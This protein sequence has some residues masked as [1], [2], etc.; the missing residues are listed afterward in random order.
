MIR[1]E[2][3][4][5]QITHRERCYI[6]ES[7]KLSCEYVETQRRQCQEHSSC[8]GLHR[9]RRLYPT[10]I[11]I[12]RDSEMQGTIREVLNIENAVACRPTKT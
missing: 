1:C 10:E 8:A 6:E 7:S 5:L 11:E 12:E 2:L 3:E 9:Q 4:Y